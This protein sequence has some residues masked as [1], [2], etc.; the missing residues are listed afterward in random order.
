MSLQLTNLYL[1]RSGVKGGEGGVVEHGESGD[2]KGAGLRRLI[3]TVS[4]LLGF[5][6]KMQTVE[7]NLLLLLHK[8]QSK[9]KSSKLTKWKQFV[10]KSQL[11]RIHANNHLLSSVLL[12][13]SFFIDHFFYC[14]MIYMEETGAPRENPV[15]HH[16]MF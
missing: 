9:L 10:E 14:Q 13:T 11:I 15:F 5:V 1:K 3:R 12:L 2:R 8:E 7:I 4:L 6:E 16:V